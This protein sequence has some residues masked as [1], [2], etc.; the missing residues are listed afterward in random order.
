MNFYAKIVLNIHRSEKHDYGN[1]RCFEVTG[2]G[3][4][5][6]SDKENSMSEYFENGDEYIGFN[7]YEDFLNKYESIITDILKIDKIANSGM[8][9]TLLNY[10]SDNQALQL[11]NSIYEKNNITRT[12]K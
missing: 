9:K 11:I 2:M 10:T 1:I 8:K 7:N 4:L 12:H 3:A 5:L 6:M